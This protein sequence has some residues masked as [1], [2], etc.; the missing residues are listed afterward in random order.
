MGIINTAAINSTTFAAA[1][2]TWAEIVAMES[3]I[4]ADNADMSRMAYL[5]TQALVGHFKTTEKFSST[6]QTIW[7]D[8]REHGQGVVNGYR[9]LSS[10]NITAGDVILGDWS[11]LLMGFWGGVELDADPYG[12]NF[13][14]GSTTV[15]VLADVD[16][17][18]RTP[19][20][21]CVSND[22]V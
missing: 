18:L 5:T 2:P 15:R 8:G 6:G 4:S 9:C 22:T 21:F 11:Q 19:V 10:G 13:L 16:F 7:T 17:A 1:N 3:A 20:S 14:K 12:T